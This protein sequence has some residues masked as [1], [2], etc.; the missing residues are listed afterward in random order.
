[1]D[2]A[3]TYL[4]GLGILPVKPLHQEGDIHSNRFHPAGFEPL[5]VEGV[6][7]GVTKYFDIFLNDLQPY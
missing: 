5:C 3:R 1:M 4:Y 2:K 7:R 6:G